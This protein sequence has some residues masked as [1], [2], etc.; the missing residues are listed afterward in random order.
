MEENGLAVNGG[1]R[2][3][4]RRGLGEA[5][6]AQHNPMVQP[7]SGTNGLPKTSYW[8][9]LWIFILLDLLLFFFVYFLP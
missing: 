2:L 3:R 8:L 5:G 7:S 4:V 6:R 1:D 9:D